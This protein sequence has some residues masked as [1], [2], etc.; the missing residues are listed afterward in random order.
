MRVERK[1]IF[2]GRT[3]GNKAGRGG[4]ECEDLKQP[5]EGPQDE[6]RTADW[7]LPTGRL[8]CQT[9]RLEFIPL[10]VGSHGKC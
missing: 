10:A 3:A 5:C 7:G 9:E 2:H 8:T 4:D 1:R 6:V